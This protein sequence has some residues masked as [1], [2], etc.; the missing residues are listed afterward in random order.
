MPLKKAL[1]ASEELVDSVNKGLVQ[2]DIIRQL[3]VEILSVSVL[4]IRPNPET[5]KALEADAREKLL[6]A[7]DE[8]I[9]HRRNASV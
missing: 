2:S 1:Q 4:S 9:Y 6:L 3:G 8:A 7:A 5:S